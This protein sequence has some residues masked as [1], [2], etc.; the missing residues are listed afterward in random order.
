MIIDVIS[1]L[2]HFFVPFVFVFN[3]RHHGRNLFDIGRAV[4]FLCGIGALNYSEYAEKKKNKGGLKKAMG[5]LGRTR[6]EPVYL[7]PDGPVIVT[8]IHIKSLKDKVKTEDLA[9]GFHILIVDMIVDIA[10]KYNIHQIALSGGVFNNKIILTNAV[11]RLN[12]NGF[13][14]Y[15]NELVPCGDGGIALGQAFIASLEE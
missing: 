10:K 6:A 15:T 7:P 9:L 13:E 12:E 14:A 1:K 11:K 8:V 3:I 5:V 4:I 2:L